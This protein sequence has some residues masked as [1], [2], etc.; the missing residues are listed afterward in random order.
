LS[1]NSLI[2]YYPLVL[3]LLITYTIVFK[4]LQVKIV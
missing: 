1:R 4:F 2:L 3:I